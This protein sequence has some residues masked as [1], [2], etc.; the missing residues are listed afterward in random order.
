MTA[1]A[2]KEPRRVRRARRA[3][4]FHNDRATRATNPLQRLQVAESALTAA[5]KHVRA[6]EVRSVRDDI[7]GH[8][9]DVLV[10]ADAGG[11]RRRLYE[12]K[13]TAGGGEV[14]RL[15]AALWCLR[16]ALQLLSTTERDQYVAH[17]TGALDDETRRLNAM[18]G[19]R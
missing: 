10:L 1:T 12:Q 14:Q 13:L 5:A 11:S 9:T 6:R 7:A 16:A 8:V 3:A 18:R 17:Y 15:A 2:R 4:A 19:G